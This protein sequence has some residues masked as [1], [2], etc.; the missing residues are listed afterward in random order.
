MRSFAINCSVISADRCEMN[1]GD[2][3]AIIDHCVRL[4]WYVT[5]DISNDY[6]KHRVVWRRDIP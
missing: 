6:T 3:G 1:G 2:E 4:Y 5:T